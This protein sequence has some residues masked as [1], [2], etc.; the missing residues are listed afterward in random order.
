MQL[1]AYRR[2][3]GLCLV[4]GQAS[5]VRGRTACKDCLAV[6]LDRYN[7][8]VLARASEGR[9]IRCG[10]REPL[11]GFVFCLP[12]RDSRRA[13]YRARWHRKV[14]DCRAR[15]VCVQCAKS[16]PVGESGFCAD[17]REARLATA[18][19]RYHRVTQERI[20]A[21]LCPR[22]GQRSPEPLMRECRPCLDRQRSYEYRGMPDLPSRYTVIEIATGI[23]HGT[24]E[25]PMEVAGAL[26]YAKLTLDDVEIVA[27]AAPMAFAGR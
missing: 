20:G 18:R 26:A 5:A 7:R 8:R 12:C 23:D 6:W 21:G 27:D 16:A 3:V 17:C 25:T 24:W 10:T 13:G 11:E 19:R 9:C 15:G 1:T 4:C 14:A 22:C 2:A